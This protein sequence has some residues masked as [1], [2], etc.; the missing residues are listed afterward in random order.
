MN[1]DLIN[2]IAEGLYCQICGQYLGQG[3]GYPRTCE[4]CLEKELKS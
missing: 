4:D 3:Y 1:E 2:G